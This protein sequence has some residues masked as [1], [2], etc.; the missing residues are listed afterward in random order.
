MLHFPHTCLLSAR[1]FIRIHYSLFKEAKALMRFSTASSITTWRIQV[2]H[3]KTTA[4]PSQMLLIY[5]AFRT[6]LVKY[7]YKGVQSINVICVITY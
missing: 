7:L 4:S 1:D 5:I 2:L 6:L 3:I